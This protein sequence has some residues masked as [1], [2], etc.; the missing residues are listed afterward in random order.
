[1]ALHCKPGSS[2][3]AP[4]STGNRASSSSQKPYSE[5][6]L[7]H[8]SLSIQMETKPDTVTIRSGK[9]EALKELLSVRET[10]TL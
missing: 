10:M 1:M 9:M 8:H 2:A 4:L 3:R 5:A 7:L 6:L